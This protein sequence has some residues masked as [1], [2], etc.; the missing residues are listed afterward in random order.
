VDNEQRWRSR[1]RWWR[2]HSQINLGIAAVILT[3]MAWT[4]ACP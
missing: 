4:A 1:D 2:R 3:V